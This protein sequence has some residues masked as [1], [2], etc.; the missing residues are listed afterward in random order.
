MILKSKKWRSNWG[1]GLF[2]PALG[3]IL[4]TLF[5]FS[6]CKYGF[7]DTSPIPAEVK[8]F[9]VNY[10]EN[11]AQYVNPQLSPQL[12]EKLKQKIIGTTRL[13][14]TNS[15]D[16]HYDISGFVSEY[17]TT[18]TGISNNSASVN[19][20]SVGFH[21][22]FKNNLD[23]KKSHEWDLSRNFDF[24]ASQTLSQAESTLNNDII[25]GLTE[26]IFNKIFSNW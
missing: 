9:R 10:L 21:L 25:N 16:A 13:R 2:L 6:T 12:T 26:D 14:Q 22:V 20:L 7:R 1:A 19:R 8:T 18:T 4:L 24:P 5:S 23:E 15:D 11:K 3:F 17:N